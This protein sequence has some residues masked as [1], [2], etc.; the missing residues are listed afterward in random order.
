ML[1]AIEEVSYPVEGVCWG[2]ASDSSALQ[3]N[4][5]VGLFHKGNTP[6]A[7]LTLRVSG[8]TTLFSHKCRVWCQVA[9]EGIFVSIGG[10]ECPLRR[11]VGG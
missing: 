7:G 11:G 5:G 2:T 9:N 4:V 6:H 3:C 10:A 1:A 8:T